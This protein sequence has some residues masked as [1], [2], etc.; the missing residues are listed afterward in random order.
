[1][2]TELAQRMGYGGLIKARTAQEVWDEWRHFS[3]SSYY[4]FEGMTYDRLKAEPGLQ[5]PCPTENHP[6][7]VRRYVEGDDPFVPEGAGVQFYG[8]KDKRAVIPFCP[9][10][11]TPEQRSEQFP[12]IL[13]TGRVIEQ[14]H[15]GT[16]TQRID[17]LRGGSGP[18]RFTI[19]EV[20]AEQRGV[21][22]GDNITVASRFGNVSGRAVIDRD[23][24]P[25]LL[26]A[27]F[28]DA[29]LLVNRVVADHFDPVSKEPEFKITAVQFRTAVS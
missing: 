14:W 24:R 23:M 22:S 20:D 25:G 19:S 18:A 29:R 15:T 17:E 16:M 27:A 8:Q 3:A 12:L 10:V 13:T 2:L 21:E 7:T 5:W 28:Y 26:F 4:N 11:P 9:Y 6:G 1:M